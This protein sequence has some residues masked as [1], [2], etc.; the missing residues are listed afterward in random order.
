M[1]LGSQLY[2]SHLCFQLQ[3]GPL[4]LGAEGN[5]SGVSDVGVLWN[6]LAERTTA[7]TRVCLRILQVF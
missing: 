2:S 6:Y 5:L 3:N 4:A 7:E 1:I